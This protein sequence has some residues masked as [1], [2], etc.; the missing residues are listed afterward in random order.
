MA[1]EKVT[2]QKTIARRLGVSATTVSRALR[3]HPGL[4]AELR[5]R[6]AREAERIGLDFTP[7]KKAQVFEN[8]HATFQVLV[9]GKAKPGSPEAR[10]TERLV[11]GMSRSARLHFAD[12]RTDYF[13][14]EELESWREAKD[15]PSHLRPDKVHGFVLIA[16]LPLRA[17]EL[18][19]AIGPCVQIV[20]RHPEIA[21]DRVDHDDSQSM[22]LLVAHLVSLGHRRIGFATTKTG[23]SFEFSRYAGYAAAL[24]QYGIEFE[25]EHV[26]AFEKNIPE[27]TSFKKIQDRVNGGVRAW[28]CV[29]DG[30]GYRVQAAMKKKG[31]HIPRDLSICGFDHLPPPEGLLPLTSIEAPF[32]VMGAAAVDRLVNSLRRLDTECAHVLFDTRLIPGETTAR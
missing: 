6:I 32:E 22:N 18:L 26:V 5:F 27:E 19:K 31:L 28:I 24:S 21:L 16:V 30:L 4:P 7:R 15:L 2:H 11:L 14:P 13:S 8:T 25:K 23:R 17:L 12:L 10:V 3:N 9:G 29:H 1:K 20:Q